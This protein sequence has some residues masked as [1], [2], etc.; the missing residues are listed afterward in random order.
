MVQMMSSLVKPVTVFANS[1]SPADVTLVKGGTISGTVRFEDGMPAVD[2]LVVL[3]RQFPGHGVRQELPSDDAQHNRRRYGRSGSYRFAG[4]P[5]GD[6][7]VFII[8][9]VRNTQPIDTA[10]V[11]A[12][13]TTSTSTLSVYYEH[14]QDFTGPSIFAKG[15]GE[16]RRQYPDSVVELHSVSGTVVDAT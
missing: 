5:E 1:S 4:L 2:S 9:S 3:Q 11:R 13:I 15:R 12:S 7:K 14:I 16:Q 6:Y 8:L 10:E